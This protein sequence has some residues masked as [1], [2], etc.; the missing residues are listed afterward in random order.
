MIFKAV[1]RTWKDDKW[2]IIM[3][4]GGVFLVLLSIFEILWVVGSGRSLVIPVVCG[5]SG[6]ILILV[7]IIVR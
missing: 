3:V 1:R 2:G 7:P 4:L 6:L 5:I